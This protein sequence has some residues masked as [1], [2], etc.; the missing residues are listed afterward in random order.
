MSRGR[1]NKSPAEAALNAEIAKRI[2][3]GEKNF[4]LAEEYSMSVCKVSRIR[5]EAGIVKRKRLGKQSSAPV[6]IGEVSY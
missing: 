5:Q 1:H 4:L 6:D 2:L 3:A